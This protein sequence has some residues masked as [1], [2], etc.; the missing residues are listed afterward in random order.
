MMITL[1]HVSRA[2]RSASFATSGIG[3]VLSSTSIAY[4]D[5]LLQLLNPAENFVGFLLTAVFG[6]I[7][8]QPL[9]DASQNRCLLE[10]R[11]VV[12][13]LN[14]PLAFRLRSP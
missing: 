6:W 7:N 13:R 1:S 9:Q 14:K 2:T 12:K 4:A 11:S 10:R 5:L 3:V 8:R